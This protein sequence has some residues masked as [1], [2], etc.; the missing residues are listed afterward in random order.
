MLHRDIYLGVCSES[1]S[2]SSLFWEHSEMDGDMFASHLSF[3]A[4]LSKA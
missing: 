4:S 1:V 2:P 3:S